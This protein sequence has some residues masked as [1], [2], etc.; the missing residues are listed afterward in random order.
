MAARLFYGLIVLLCDV[1]KL[2][3]LGVREV[4]KKAEWVKCTDTVGSLVVCVS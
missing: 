3:S 4:F 1:Q 2:I